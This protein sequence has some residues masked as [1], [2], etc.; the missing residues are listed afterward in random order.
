MEGG[1]GIW[2]RAVVRG[3]GRREGLLADFSRRRDL[4]WA[5]LLRVRGRDEHPRDGAAADRR[6]VPGRD[7]P[8]LRCRES[9]RKGGFIVL[10]L[11][12]KNNCLVFSFLIA[13]VVFVS[14]I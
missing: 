8:R 1:A 7:R 9:P 14:F 5:W 2:A 10:V 13:L 11:D 12:Y 4:L 6:E 3:L